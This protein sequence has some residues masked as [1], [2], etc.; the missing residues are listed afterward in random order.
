MKRWAWLATAALIVILAGSVSKAS[1]DEQGW[2]LTLH[3][4]QAGYM[5]LYLTSEGFVLVV[6]ETGANFVTHSPDWR[7]VIYNNQ[8]RLY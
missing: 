4:P 8:T 2:G 3:S 5:Y 1:A 6:K 7:M